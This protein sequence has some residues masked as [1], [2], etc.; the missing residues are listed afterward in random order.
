MARYGTEQFK[1]WRSLDLESQQL[2]HPHRPVF[3]T[4]R[5]SSVPTPSSKKDAHLQAALHKVR[6]AGGVVCTGRGEGEGET[7]NG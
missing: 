4:Q 2:C 7:V 3:K 5:S 6:T 1:P